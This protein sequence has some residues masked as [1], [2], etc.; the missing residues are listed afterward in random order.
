MKLFENIKKEIIKIILERKR[1]EKIMIFGSRAN[2]NGSTA[3]DIDIA[4][5]GESWTDTDINMVKNR[6]EEEI[7]TPLKFDVLSYNGL[8]KGKLKENIIKTGKVIYDS[9]KDK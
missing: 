5:F 9:G 2:G 1:V 7:K 3:S 8:S 6:M 4:I